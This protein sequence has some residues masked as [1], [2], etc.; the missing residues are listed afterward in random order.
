MP[1]RRFGAGIRLA[2]ATFTVLPVPA[3]R[4]D[5]SAAGP[6]MLLA[7][8][9]GAL[10]GAL[11]GAVTYLPGPTLVLGGLAVGLSA[12]L[13]RGLHLDGLADT[14]DGLGSFRRGADA[15]AVMRRP[16]VGPFGVATL[17]VVLLLQ[18]GAYPALPAPVVGA[19]VALA[20]GRLAATWACR[21]GVPAAAPDG[22]G[23]LVAGSV[24]VAAAAVLTVGVGALSALAVD[25]RWWQG[26]LAVLAGLAVAEVLVRHAVRRFGGINGDVLGAAIELATTV[27][28]IGLVLR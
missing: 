2:L 3:G 16:D 15:L 5:R 12:L 22:L 14:A 9:V 8:V 23:A 28:L 20:T 6:A 25:G 17:V 21:R 26:P 18:A 11:V 24:P 7:P 10:L 13:T 27:A 19:A 1:E 4:V